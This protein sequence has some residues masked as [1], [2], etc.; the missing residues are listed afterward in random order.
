MSKLNSLQDLFLDEIKDLHNAE[1]QIIATLPKMARKATNPELKSA[2]EEHLEQTK[3]HVTRLEQVFESIGEK[4]AGK[5]CKA[6]FF[7]P[8]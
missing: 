5:T 1:K 3:N 2:F 7:I 8:I 4:V 6:I